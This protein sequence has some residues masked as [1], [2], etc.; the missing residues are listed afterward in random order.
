MEVDSRKR[1]L[2]VVVGAGASFDC[3]SQDVALNLHFPIQE[4]LRPPL[5]T[6]LF[7][8]RFADIRD[9]YPLVAQ[10]APS[11]RLALRS[12]DVVALEDYLQDELRHSPHRH[13]REA[14]WA[15]PLYLQHVLFEVSNG[16]TREP[17]NYDRLITT[18]LQVDRV[19]FIT[20]NYDTILDNRLAIQARSGPDSMRWYI[21]TNRKWSLVKL[22]GSINWRRRI[23][24]AGQFSTKT[25]TYADEFAKLGDHIELDDTIELIPAGGIQSHR[26]QNDSDGGMSLLFPALAVPVR[27]K[28]EETW[29]PPDHI[30][31]IRDHMTYS[32]DGFNILVIGY[33]AIDDDVLSLFRD[34]GRPL[35][36]LLVVDRDREDALQVVKRFCEQLPAH[37]INP[38]AAAFDGD[39]Q[40][41]AQSAALDEY[42]ASV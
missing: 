40:S 19:T 4:R 12:S 20:L 14:Y 35:R 23:L 2:F 22:H 32:F 16:F 10:I 11:I 41:F 9:Q 13:L 33:R 1:H 5:V 25:E 27:T 17:D 24:N 30:A 3:V 26:F 18:T 42:V 21:D 6:G 39:F 34:A 38:N 37:G 7:D 8:G 36:S 29:C 15:I 31:D 28:D